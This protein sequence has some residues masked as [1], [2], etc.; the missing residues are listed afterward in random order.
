M[1]KAG[2][3][4]GIGS[5]K[6]LVAEVFK[7]LGVPVFN[8]DAEAKNLYSKPEVLRIIAGHFGNSVLLPDGSL[9]R[10][11]LASIVFSDKESLQKLNSI[12][13]PLVESAF[14]DWLQQN[15]S[16][17]YTIHEAAILYESGFDRFFDKV[18]VVDA[19]QELCIARVIDR[20][21]IT[22]AQV[23]ERMKN[24]W[25]PERKAS[26]ADFLIVNDGEQ[27]VL[28]QVLAIHKYLM[29]MQGDQE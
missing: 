12:I 14:I 13:H 6:S 11:A 24:Q 21:N 18:I 17:A 15:A 22:R 3:T 28:P 29:H 9:D 1:I 2:L 4:G 5:G 27:M 19:P 26:K 23:L 10:K 8:A 7:H 25:E 16:S 20:D